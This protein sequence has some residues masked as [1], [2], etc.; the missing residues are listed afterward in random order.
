M[1]L[2]QLE[3]Y[4][5]N[6]IYEFLQSL[7]P[8]LKFKNMTI[9][10]L[11]LAGISSLVAKYTGFDP[12]WFVWVFL[13]VFVELV[14]GLAASKIKAKKNKK[15][16]KL[17]SWKFSRFALK[18]FIWMFLFAFVGGMQ[19]SFTKPDTIARVIAEIL[20]YGVAFSFFLEYGI[21]I[22]ENVRAING[23]KKKG[24]LHEVTDRTGEKIKD[25]IHH[26]THYESDE[27]N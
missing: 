10:V 25:S 21:S 23:K 19:L 15:K 2:K 26:E 9:G 14:S 27:D 20:M 24:F 17:E 5:W 3:D 7:A 4:G 22:Y 16:W 1:I 8:S 6:S 13:A 12:A 18:V 11:C